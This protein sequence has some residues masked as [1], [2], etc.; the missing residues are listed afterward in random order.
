MKKSAKIPK[1]IHPTALI[2]P[3]AELGKD[4]M[5]GPYCVVGEHARSVERSG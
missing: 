2:H 5:I 1:T 3:K 4:V